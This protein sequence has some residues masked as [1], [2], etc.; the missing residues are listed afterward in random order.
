MARSASAFAGEVDSSGLHE[1]RTRQLPWWK[2]IGILIAVW[3]A[4]TLARM[5]VVDDVA[6]A[7]ANARAL[8]DIERL[9]Y[10]DPE[11]SIVHWVDAHKAVALV[12]CYAYASLHYVV[13]ASVVVWTRL[14]RPEIF[15][16]ARD[17]LVLATLIALACYWLIPMAPPR[18][19][20]DGFIDVMA[21]YADFGWWGTHASAPPG[22]APWTNEFAAFPSMHVGWAVWCGWMLTGARTRPVR[23]LGLTYPVFVTF[24]VVA[25]GNHFLL[26]AVAG[27]AA[28]IVS[29][30]IARVWHRDRLRTLR[31]L[32]VR[33]DE[34]AIG[35]S[36]RS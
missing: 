22:T 5:A 1:L 18:L 14:R 21:S 36:G 6:Q 12:T 23:L 7:K 32:T 26:D 19:I 13:T 4:Y 16:Y 11:L 31:S 10:L 15:P 34:V 30:H 9:L 29:A 8:L 35:E 3:G 27:A 33:A 20:G 17:T 2:E 25:T 24:V 28:I